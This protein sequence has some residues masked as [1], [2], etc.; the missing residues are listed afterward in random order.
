MAFVYRAEM[1]TR[2]HPP[3]AVS[4]AKEGRKAAAASA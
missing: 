1:A 3:I 2:H 4:A